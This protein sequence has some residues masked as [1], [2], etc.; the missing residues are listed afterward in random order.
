MKIGWMA[1]LAAAALTAAPAGAS[2]AFF[3]VAKLPQPPVTGKEIADDVAEFSTTYSPRVTGTPGEQDAAEFLRAEAESLGYATETVLLP[4]VGP[5]PGLVLRVVLATKRGVTKP[6]EHILFM[7]HYDTV[8]GFGG[9][10][11]NGAYDNASGTNM[12]RALARSFAKIPTN[13][14]LVFAW[15]NGEEEG[16]L[17]SQAHAARWKASGEAIRAVLGFDMV[18]IAYPV[19]NPGGPTCLCIWHGEDDEAFEP[20]LR[21]VHYEVLGFPE[22]DELVSFQGVNARNSDESSWDLE[23]YPTLRWAGMRAASDYPAYHMPD[24]TME[25]IDAVAGGRTY[26]EQ[27]LRNT[28]LASYTTALA[29]DNEMPTATAAASGDRTVSFDAA[30]SGDPDGQPGSY[31]WSFGDGEKATGRQVTHTYSKPG[32]YDA[33]LTVADNLWPQVTAT[34]TAPVEVRGSKPAAK[35]KSTKKKRCAKRK[36]KSKSKT[37]RSRRSARCK[38]KRT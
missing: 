1:A 12:M 37:K 35:K 13:R 10:T 32:H 38:R 9:V 21:H 22:G 8:A 27:G 3:D 20:L 6:D 19:A 36:S 14:T 31:T 30:G 33:T 2:A 29:V 7:G 23:G 18:G 5:E 4:V 26:F 24:D 17:A 15:Y 28:L 34:A 11:I 16:V 25:T